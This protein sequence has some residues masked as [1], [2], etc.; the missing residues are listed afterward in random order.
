MENHAHE[1][2]LCCVT[3]S[4]LLSVV[5][6]HEIHFFY[7]E[8]AIIRKFNRAMQNIQVFDSEQDQL[9]EDGESSSDDHTNKSPLSRDM[10]PIIE[11]EKVID[12]SQL[13]N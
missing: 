2:Y 13:D 10:E 1:K 3:A 6:K 4:T 5:S 8:V 9:S 12:E 11:E 7:Q